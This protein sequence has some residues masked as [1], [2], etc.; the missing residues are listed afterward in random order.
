MKELRTEY[1]GEM[2]IHNAVEE[3]KNFFI[4]NSAASI[5]TMGFR[6]RDDII[7]QCWIR[8]KQEYPNLT[9]EEN[10]QIMEAFRSSVWGYGVLDP[11]IK[12]P[13]ISD[14][15]VYSAY[16]IRTKRIGERMDAPDN[17]HFWTDEGY[18]AF[19]NQIAARNNINLGTINAI[20]TFTD[21]TLPEWTLRITI[22]TSVLM[23]SGL[24]LLHIRKLSKNKPDFSDLER[25]GMFSERKGKRRKV[26]DDVLR[27]MERRGVTEQNLRF[28]MEELALASSGI[29]ICGQGGA[30][31]STLYNAIL[32]KIPWTQ[33][34]LIIQENRELFS[35]M[36]PDLAFCH[37]MEGSGEGKVRFTLAEETKAALLLD[38]DLI[39]IGEIKGNEAAE[40]AKAVQTGHRAICTVHGTDCRSGLEKMA[41]YI[42]Q[43][44]GYSMALAKRQLTGFQ[45]V[46]FLS[47]YQVAEIV[48]VEG[49]DP[50]TEDLKLR[51][52]YEIREAA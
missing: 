36:H 51:R 2:S 4:A 22:V 30:G 52:I 29:L 48:R 6:E 32:E 21:K 8:L 1:E 19:V 20:Q 50:M 38:L 31:K 33:S 7:R 14:I 13:E 34:G 15:K 12:D 16:Q 11:L 27:E 18:K 39:G 43:A 41:D 10:Q 24:P 28:Y 35:W 17:V 26:K 44:T 49:W 42:A 40:L 25:E 46:I 23:D 3:L 37:L 9:P 47:E 5:F 45:H